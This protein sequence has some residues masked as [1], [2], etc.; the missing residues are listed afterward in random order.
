MNRPI[1][2]RVWDGTTKKWIDENDFCIWQ[3][4][5]FRLEI[6][7]TET[8]SYGSSYNPIKLE[9]SDLG[10]PF[11][12]D[13]LI[14][15]QFTGLKDKNGKEIYE[16]DIVYLD[17][18]NLPEKYNQ[19]NL[20]TIEFNHGSFVINPKK[21]VSKDGTQNFPIGKQLSGFDKDSNEIW[22]D[23]WPSCQSIFNYNICVVI[24]NIFEN[25]ELLK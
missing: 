3:E 25:K 12:D 1:K 18:A 16:G 4:K 13:K 22:E 9:E 2:F 14:P 5:A 21:F 15:Q 10:S 19:G 7:G 8:N 17:F 23:V 6:G 20:F 24:G 11:Y